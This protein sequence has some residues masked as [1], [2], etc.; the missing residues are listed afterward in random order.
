M[1][2]KLSEETIK[3]IIHVLHSPT[4]YRNKVLVQLNVIKLS[5]QQRAFVFP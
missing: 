1:L 4:T 2:V 3:T 5:K